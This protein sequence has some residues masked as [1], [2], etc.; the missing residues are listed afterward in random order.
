[1]RGTVLRG[2]SNTAK[3]RDKVCESNTSP[4]RLQSKPCW[5]KESKTT[6]ITGNNMSFWSVFGGGNNNADDLPSAG[7]AQP[8]RTGQETLLSPGAALNGPPPTG[9]PLSPGAPLTGPPP[10][11]PAYVHSPQPPS[12]NV[13][14]HPPA[15]QHSHQSFKFFNQSQTMSPRCLVTRQRMRANSLPRLTTDTNTTGWMN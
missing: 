7:S 1:M 10:T 11:A 3:T 15:K 6:L 14:Y 4:I 2:K 8:Q 5:H 12:Q 9:A 13:R